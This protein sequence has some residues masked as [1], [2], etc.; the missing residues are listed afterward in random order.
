MDGIS[1]ISTKAENNFLTSHSN[2]KKLPNDNKISS[3][4]FCVNLLFVVQNLFS[5]G[6][7]ITAP[8]SMLGL[9][10]NYFCLTV[11]KIPTGKKT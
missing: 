5:Q 2:R 8:G 9:N 7:Y 3:K 1:F 4:S 10:I 6:I 11:A